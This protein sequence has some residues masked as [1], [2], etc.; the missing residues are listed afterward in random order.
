MTGGNSRDTVIKIKELSG[1]TFARCMGGPR[2]GARA[3]RVFSRQGCF[4]RPGPHGSGEWSANMGS[5][6]QDGRLKGV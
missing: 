6:D 4:D 1:P 3:G 5:V 2:Q